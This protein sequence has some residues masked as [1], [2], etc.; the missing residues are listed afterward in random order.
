MINGLN[1]SML[2]DP[3]VMAQWGLLLLFALTFI[4]Q[5]GLPLPTFPLM[6]VAGA[7]ARQTGG[8]GV[9][10]VLSATLGSLAGGVI[11]FYIGRWKGRRVLGLLCRVSLS[12]DLCVRQT[13]LAFEQRGPLA[14]V[15]ARFLP[16]LALLAPPLAG[17]TGMP[18]STFTVFHGGGVLVRSV[19]AILMG[20]FFQHEMAASLRWAAEHTHQALVLIGV[21]LLAWLIR[22]YR[23]RRRDQIKAKIPRISPLDLLQL[24][25]SEHT[26][27]HVLDAR[28]QLARDQ[29]DREV[30]RSV[31]V[32]LNGL[33]NLPSMSVDH[34]VVTYCACPND[35]SAVELAHRVMRRYKK[36]RSGGPRVHVLA[37]GLDA[38]YEEVVV[39]G[40]CADSNARLS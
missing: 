1:M 20:A 29:D 12:P 9:F 7:V 16:G 36:S 10:E 34:A 40:R 33:K 22:R 38:W 5:L 14:L 37:G 8:T 11:W 3:Q 39:K 27:V 25:N 18:L 35:A 4:E 26:T 21:F 30:P 15:L 19:L 28:S 24:L 32:D 2:L 17:G 13:E 31:A 6:I 23:I